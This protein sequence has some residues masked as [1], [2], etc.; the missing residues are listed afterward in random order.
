MSG[1]YRRVLFL[2]AALLAMPGTV[3]VQ[4]GEDGRTR[5]GKDWPLYGGDWSSAR[6]STLTQINASNVKTLGG[7]WT[8]K[9]DG[10][11]STRATP[12]VKDGIMFISTVATL[13]LNA[14]AVRR[15]GPGAGATAPAGSNLPGIGLSTRFRPNPPGALGEAW[16]SSGV[17]GTRRSR[18]GVVWTRNAK[19]Q[20][21]GRVGSPSY[22]T[23]SCAPGWPTA[24]GHSMEGIR[25]RCEDRQHLV[26]VHDSRAR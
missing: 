10:N 26:G 8:M 17:D 5:P 20:E 25:A 12:I 24:I 7:A 16:C 14:K 2:L 6:H 22:A 13:A 11:A 4:P 18:R 1:R 21:G 9:F 3:L 19:S 15:C 23:A